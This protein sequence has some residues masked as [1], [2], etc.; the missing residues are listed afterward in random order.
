[1][2]VINASKI[3][4]VVPGELSAKVKKAVEDAEVLSAKM[5]GPETLPPAV[6]AGILV[7]QGIGAPKEREY[8][9]DRKEGKKADSFLG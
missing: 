4:K 6:L 5:G 7:S 9:E 1:M 2:D 3:K 8:F